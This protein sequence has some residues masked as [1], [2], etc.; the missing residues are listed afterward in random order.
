MGTNHINPQP[1]N[2]K[3]FSLPSVEDKGYGILL[4]TGGGGSKTE[5]DYQDNKNENEKDGGRILC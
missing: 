4:E 1:T 2:H 3:T 5:E